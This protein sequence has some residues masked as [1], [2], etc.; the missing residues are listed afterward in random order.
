[1]DLRGPIEIACPYLGFGDLQ[2]DAV[3]PPVLLFVLT[4]GDLRSFPEDYPHAHRARAVVASCSRRI[5]GSKYVAGPCE[6]QRYTNGVQVSS[7]PGTSIRASPTQ[8]DFIQET[9][10]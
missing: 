5:V 8:T 10:D 3:I 1:M 9:F 7:H 6:S 2:E 4:S